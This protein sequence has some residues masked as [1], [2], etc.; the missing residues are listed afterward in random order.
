MVF[1]V[2]F[3]RYVGFFIYRMKLTLTGSRNILMERY[4]CMQVENLR[5]IEQISEIQLGMNQDPICGR[6]K[7]ENTKEEN[8]ILLSL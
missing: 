5:G 3:E 7:I 1:A 6:L 8:L 2:G 4:L